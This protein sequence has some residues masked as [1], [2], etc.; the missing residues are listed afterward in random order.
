MDASEIVRLLLLGLALVISAF[1]SA[2][3]A[4]FLSVRRSRLASL[5]SQGV[6]RAALVARLA[7]RPEKLL[8][9]VLTGNN[10]V[11]VAAAA[12]GTTLAASYL[13]PN[14][15]VVAS[16]AGVTVLLLLFAEVLPKTMATK[17]AESFAMLAVRPLQAAEILFFPAVWVLERFS[18]LVAHL[19][20][21]SGPVPL[22]EA[23][24]RSLIGIAETEGVVEKSEAQMLEKVFHF[25]D[26]Q[27]QEIMTPRTE[28]VW[29]EQGM[30]LQ[31][32]LAQYI[33]E[34]HTRFPVFQ[35]DMEN[36]VG[37]LS[38]KD[39]LQAMAQEGLQP[40]SSVTDVLRPAHVVPETKLIG[41]LFSELR[42]DGQQMA[43]VVDE[44]SGVAGLVT[45]KRLLE[46][47]VGPVG[48]EGEPAEEEFAAIGENTYDVD[49]GMAVQEANEE[50]GL[51]LPE[52]NYQTL[53]GFILDRLG[54]IP[55]EGEE[56]RYKNLCLEIT[57]MKRVKIER[58]LISFLPGPE[59][60]S[61]E[62]DR[63]PSGVIEAQS[64]KNGL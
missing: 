5:D 14:W 43:I 56:L 20:K 9:T 18:R 38:V 61:P 47:I 34:T 24:V 3:E 54:Y 7:R 29:V 48:E 15:A 21:A 30:T 12:L 49:A 4:A 60:P 16:T 52:G 25:G 37:V 50:L 8:P 55:E 26:R 42:Q 22:T 23:D 19:L 57:E 32:F 2:S 11:N 46:V 59:D 10:L 64:K 28:I 63:D 39:L 27:V 51:G 53:A 44:Y 58:L 62:S 35:G 45:L 41:Q 31:D 1:F 13:T 17:R 36:V 40:D 33:L 6:K